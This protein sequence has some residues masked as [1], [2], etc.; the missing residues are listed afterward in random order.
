MTNPLLAWPTNQT[1]DPMPT[2]FNN[3]CRC[4]IEVWRVYFFGP[5][6]FHISLQLF[7]L[8][9]LGMKFLPCSTH[10]CVVYGLPIWLGSLVLFSAKDLKGLWEV[11][12]NCFH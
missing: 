8:A 1:K 5:A 7:A 10:T 6:V 9:S 12:M 2:T 4:K 3:Y 11:K